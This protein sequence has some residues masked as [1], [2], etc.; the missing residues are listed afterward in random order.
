[1]MKKLVLVL[2]LLASPAAA[3]QSMDPATMQRYLNE[4]Q[5]MIMERTNDV[6]VAR[7]EVTRLTEELQ[8]LKA[9]LP[10]P[11]TPEEK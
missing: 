11:K 7:S 5:R 4:M 3:A 1:M 8:K 2:A 10:P 9:Q 6:V